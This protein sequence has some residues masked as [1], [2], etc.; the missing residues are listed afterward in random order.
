[1]ATVVML[2]VLRLS[3][4]CH[5]LYEGVWKINNADKFSAAPFLSEAKGPAAR[6]FYAMLPDLYGR[7]R[8]QV[9]KDDSGKVVRDKEGRP[10]IRAESTLAV[11]EEWK[12]R[13][14]RTH[15]LSDAQKADAQKL[16]DR[17]RESLDKY[18][19]ENAAEI[20]GYFDGL[21]RL[22]AEGKAGNDG[23]AHQQERAWKRE[24]LLRGELA[25]WLGEIEGM[26][27]EYQLGLWDLLDDA[28]KAKGPITASD[29]WNPLSWTRIEQINFAVTY[30]LTAI[31][32]C[33][34][35]GLFTRLAAM[36]GAAF[37]FFVVL[38]QPAWPGLYPPDPAVVGHALLVNKDL[39]EMVALLVVATTAVGRWG[40]LDFFLYNFITRPFLSRRIQS[41]Q[42]EGPR[43]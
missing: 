25:V 29:W 11:W 15:G 20:A 18:L 43:R 35:A 5:F 14:G 17:Y 23:A 6:F 27:K 19:A 10:V 4:G 7:E 39:V 36:G 16:F 40:G 32:L 38:T 21:D 30:G 1:M 34:M 13:V 31:G 9:A 41:T 2:V 33:L 8:L 42:K 24:R 37:M 26:G 12:D 28:Q 3:L 22:E